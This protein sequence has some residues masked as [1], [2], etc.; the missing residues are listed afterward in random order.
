MRFLNPPKAGLLNKKNTKTLNR[1]GIMTKK[2]LKMYFI[3]AKYWGVQSLSIQLKMYEISQNQASDFWKSLAQSRFTRKLPR[4]FCKLPHIFCS[5]HAPKGVHI[6][7][8][9]RCKCPRTICKS[10]RNRL[11]HERRTERTKRKCRRNPDKVRCISNGLY[12]PY[13]CNASRNFRI[14]PYTPNKRQYR[15]SCLS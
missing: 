13:Q 6:R 14:R 5:N 4:I 3:Y 11:N 15:L 9:K 12:W 1:I 8:R 7:Q 10:R 2:W